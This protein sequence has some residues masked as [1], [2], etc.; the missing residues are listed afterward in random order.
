MK[1][2]LAIHT[3][4]P[5]RFIHMNMMIACPALGVLRRELKALKNCMH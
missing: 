5:E 4:L 1:F 3:I 2:S